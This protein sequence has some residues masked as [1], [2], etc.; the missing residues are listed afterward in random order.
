[1]GR[2]GERVL[3]AAFFDLGQEKIKYNQALKNYPTS[4]LCFTGLFALMDPPKPGVAE[5]ITAAHK[6]GIF[7]F[8]L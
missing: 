8:L 7:R 1:L 5:A 2:K 3:G 4:N 6:A